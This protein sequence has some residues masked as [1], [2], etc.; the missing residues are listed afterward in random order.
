MKRQKL[1]HQ[2]TW[3]KINKDKTKNLLVGTLITEK[4]LAAMVNGSRIEEGWAYE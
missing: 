2:M 4:Q 3:K 1:K